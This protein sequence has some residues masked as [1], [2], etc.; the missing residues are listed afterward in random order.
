MYTMV[1]LLCLNSV[2][3]DQCNER[4]AVTVNKPVGTWPT[5]MGCAVASMAIL[6][7]LNGD[8]ST[9]SVVTCSRR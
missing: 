2:P 5:A 9:H 3:K 6:P 4:T 7:V 8:D 1:I